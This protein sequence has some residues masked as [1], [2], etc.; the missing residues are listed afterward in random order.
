MNKYYVYIHIDP[1]TNLVRY[2]GKGSG[3][4]AYQFHPAR[5]SGYHLTWLKSLKSLG[6]KP[7]VEL[8]EQNLTEEQSFSL[9][10]LWIA[11]YR[12]LGF[13]ITNL[14]DGGEG[15][16]GQKWT[17]ER[18]NKQSLYSGEKHHSF[19]KPGPNK[20]KKFTE[21]HL[22]RLSESHKGKT[23]AMKGKNFP[24]DFGKKVS[25]SKKGKPAPN[26]KKIRGVNIE[27]LKE[28]LAESVKAMSELTNISPSAVA[29]SA[30]KNKPVFSWTF[31]YLQEAA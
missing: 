15:A 6:M 29:N 14:T 31:Q 9:E 30:R 23:S 12:H 11:A 21:E 3:K 18:R 2:V 20:G 10:K 28:V 4:R 22:K 8:I 1:R 17:Q 19:G 5:R 25:E 16:S 24:S 7:T 13:P 26:R 27:T